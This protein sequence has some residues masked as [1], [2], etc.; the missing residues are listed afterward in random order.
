MA[1]K[2]VTGYLQEATRKR[3]EEDKHL[4]AVNPPADE[5][6]IAIYSLLALPNLINSLTAEQQSKESTFPHPFLRRSR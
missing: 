6:S 4:K 3:V 5:P 1:S 2:S